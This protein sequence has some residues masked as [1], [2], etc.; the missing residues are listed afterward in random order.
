MQMAAYSFILKGDK[1][2]GGLQRCA[3]E[4]CGENTVTQMYDRIVLSTPVWLCYRYPLFMGKMMW[5]MT[6]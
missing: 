4:I 6:I 1:A 5:K 3:D 2:S